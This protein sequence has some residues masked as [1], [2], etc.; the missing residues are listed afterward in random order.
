[1]GACY[2]HLSYVDRLSIDEGLRAGLSLRAIA[3]KLKRAP[4]TVSRDIRRGGVPISRAMMPR[5]PFSAHSGVG[6]K[7]AAAPARLS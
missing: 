2:D 7:A 5:A 6:E 4:S 1:M 3:R